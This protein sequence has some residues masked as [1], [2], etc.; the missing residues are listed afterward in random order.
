MVMMY[1]IYEDLFS[2]IIL[3]HYDKLI[4]NLYTNTHIYLVTTEL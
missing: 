3:S 4:L 1:D 2:A